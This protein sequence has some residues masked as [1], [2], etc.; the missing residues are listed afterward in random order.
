M[1]KH[2]VTHRMQFA[3]NVAKLHIML[4][5]MMHMLGLFVVVS[6]SVKG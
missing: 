4:R 5:K 1:R 3:S 2:D 6:L